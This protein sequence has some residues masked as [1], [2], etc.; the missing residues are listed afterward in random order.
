MTHIF[1]YHVP[2]PAGVSAHEIA[3]VVETRVQPPAG[4]EVELLLVVRAKVTTD[5]NRINA[6]IATY[7]ALAE[8]F[9]KEGIV[10][11]IGMP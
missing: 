4:V 1:T 9:A 2:V 7:N 11:K 6:T 3:E 10:L 5:Y 8:A